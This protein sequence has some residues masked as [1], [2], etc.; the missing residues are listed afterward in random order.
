MNEWQKA[1]S[2]TIA[3]KIQPIPGGWINIVQFGE[4][5]NLEQGQARRRMQNLIQNGMAE[6][7]VFR[8]QRLCRIYPVRHY[9]LIKKK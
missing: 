8:M 9:R 7:K 3:D 6:C 2:E 4:L 5:V 1:L